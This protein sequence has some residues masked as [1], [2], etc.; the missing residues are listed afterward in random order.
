MPLRATVGE[1][2]DHDEGYGVLCVD[3]RVTTRLL[4]W[5]REMRQ[6]RLLLINHGEAREDD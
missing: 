1:V 3:V 2:V 6:E 5:E 4:A